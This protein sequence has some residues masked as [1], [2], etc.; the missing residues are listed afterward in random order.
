MKEKNGS[1]A[2][3]NSLLMVIAIGALGWNG[4]ATMTLIQKVARLES[5]I[6]IRMEEFKSVEKRVS[7]VEAIVGIKPKAVP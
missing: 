2:N 3:F 6:E 4:A 7:T 1:G 5:T